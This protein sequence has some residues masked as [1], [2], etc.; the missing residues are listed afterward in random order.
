M[1]DEQTLEKFPAHSLRAVL[2]GISDIVVSWEGG[3]EM[4][5][6]IAS[7]FAQIERMYLPIFYVGEDNK[8]VLK[9]FLCSDKNNQSKNK[10]EQRDRGPGGKRSRKNSSYNASW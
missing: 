5:G 9:D 1:M 3:E 8:L 6:R 10:S 4:T 2:S 7:H